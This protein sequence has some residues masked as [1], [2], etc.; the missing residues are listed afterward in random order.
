MEKIHAPFHECPHLLWVSARDHIPSEEMTPPPPKSIFHLYVFDA[1]IEFYGLILL[2]LVCF[3][4]LLI[5]KPMKHHFNGLYIYESKQRCVPDQR[6]GKPSVIPLT[7]TNNSCPSIAWIHV[8]FR[9]AREIVLKYEG[10]LTRTRGYQA[11]GAEV[12]FLSVYPSIHP[13]CFCFSPFL[14]IFSSV[15]ERLWLGCAFLCLSGVPHLFTDAALKFM[16]CCYSLV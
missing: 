1:W 5:K 7:V 6:T 16:A 11:A 8:C 14:F 15:Y 10:R 2:L 3:S 13:S 4:F 12:C 9:Q